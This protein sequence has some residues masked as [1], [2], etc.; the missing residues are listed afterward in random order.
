MP[1]QLSRLPV[2]AKVKDLNTRYY[3]KPIVFQV[4]DKNHAGYPNNSVTLLTD[5]IITLKAFD[6]KESGGDSDRVNYG[7]NRYSLSNIRQWL[8][9]DTSPWYVA[10]HSYDNPPNNANVW[11]NFNE[12]DAEA[13]FLTNFSA[14]LKAKLLLT[15]LTVAKA[16]VDGGGSE[17]VQDKVFL[18]SE[19]EVGLGNEN[20]IAEGTPFSIFNSDSARQAYPTSEAVSNSEYTSSS[21]NTSQSWY[22]RL[23]TPYAGYS[24]SARGVHSSGSLSYYNAF[25]GSIGVRPALNLPSDI[26]VSDTVDTDGAYVIVWDQTPTI[27]GSD[28]NLGNKAVSFTIDYSVDDTDTADTLTV[29][30]KVDATTIRTINNAV[31]GQTYTLDL[32]SV[33]SSLSLGSHTITI[34]V[35]DGKGGSATRA[36]TFTKTD[37]RIKFT[38]KNPIETSIA[39]KKIVVSGVLTIPEGATLNIKACNNGYDTSP[40]WEDVTQAFKNKEAYAF[41]NTD[42]TATNWG[43]NLQFEILKGTATESI[44]VDGFGFSFE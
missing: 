43:I 41:S 21:L 31:R 24:S 6:A 17:T 42:K 34:T 8:N 26:L 15:T 3:G 5:K 19:T 44:V 35:A 9:K 38:L 28:S 11:S 16:T 33:W 13:G 37:D 27:S 25:N 32:S 22:W 12:Y 7:N 23:R 30:E 29:T 20:G 14:E 36:Y 39:A 18:L 40:T 4:I 2:G 1:Q 10:Q